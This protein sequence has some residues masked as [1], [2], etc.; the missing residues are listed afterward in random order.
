MLYALM[1]STAL[2]FFDLQQN[3]IRKLTLSEH[4]LMHAIVWKKT[5]YKKMCSLC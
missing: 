3:E 4:K 5:R 2:I 1:S